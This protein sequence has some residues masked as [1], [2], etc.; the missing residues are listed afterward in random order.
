[1]TPNDVRLFDCFI[2]LLVFQTSIQTPGHAC[3]SRFSSTEKQEMK[4]VSLPEST[5]GS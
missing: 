2:V 5:L 1:L 3:L 4:A